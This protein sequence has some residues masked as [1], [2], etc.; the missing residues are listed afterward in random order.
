MTLYAAVEGTWPFRRTS[1]WSTLAAI[2]TEPLPEPIRAGALTPVLH[3]LMTKDPENRPDAGRAR[4]LLEQ[5]AAG[6][7]VQLPRPPPAPGAPVAPEASTA[8]AAPAAPAGPPVPAAPAGAA[9]AAF[10]AAASGFGPPP[11]PHTAQPGGAQ[12]LAPHPGGAYSGGPRSGGSPGGGPGRARRR[13]RALVAAAVAAVLLA[14]GGVTYALTGN[15]GETKNSATAP[16]KGGSSPGTADEGGGKRAR[17]KAPGTSPSRGHTKP[18]GPPAQR[19]GKAGEGRAE[20]KS[21]SKPEP[22]DKGGGGASRPDPTSRPDSP[23]KSCGGWSHRNP[24][25]GTYGYMS[26]TYHLMTG[27]YQNCQAVALAKSGTKLWYHCSVV[28]AHGHNW[29]YVRVAGTNTTGW[30]SNDNLTRQN[31]ASTRC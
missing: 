23:S 25:P 5:I 7:T 16:S 3:A 14:G 6:G 22:G 12:P 2:V 11:A 29:T 1:V 15:D 24:K 9:A 20:D 31:G 19:P 21:G 8:P 17:K 30:M 4:E 28:N 10:E 13:G 18:S 27:P 26:G